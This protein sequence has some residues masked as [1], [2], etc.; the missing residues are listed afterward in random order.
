MENQMFKPIT[1]VWK[2]VIN[3]LFKTKY[4][5]SRSLDNLK[6]MNRLSKMKRRKKRWQKIKETIEKY[7]V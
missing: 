2:N 5:D 1:E 7:D 6:L 3:D 4:L